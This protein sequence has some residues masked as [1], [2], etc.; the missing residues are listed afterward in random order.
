MILEK[1]KPIYEGK[2]SCGA[3]SGGPMV[4][5][6]KEGSMGKISYLS[7][8]VSFGPDNQCGAEKMPGV[9]TKVSSFAKV[10]N[11]LVKAKKQLLNFEDDSFNE[12]DD[13]SLLPI[14]FLK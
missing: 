12:D 7:G 11:K 2:D 9:Y 6:E 5:R 13:H 8:I 4:C 3:D 14:K 1:G 10:I